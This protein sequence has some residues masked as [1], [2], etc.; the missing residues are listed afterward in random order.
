MEMF[1]KPST[2]QPVEQHLKVLDMGPEARENP[3]D[4]DRGAGGWTPS[5][6]APPSVTESCHVKVLN[7]RELTL[8]PEPIPCKGVPLETRLSV[9]TPFVLVFDLTLLG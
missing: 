5:C 8:P 4:G 6:T 3:F 7:L 2:R 9:L 1:L